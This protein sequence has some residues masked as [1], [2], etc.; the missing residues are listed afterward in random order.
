MIR[1]LIW[2]VALLPLI[3]TIFG[4]LTEVSPDPVK[5]IYTW[6]G[7]TS[8]VILMISLG[9]SSFKRH[10]HVNFLKYRRL[11]GLFAF[12]YAL[13]HFVNFAIIDA[14]L[15]MVFIIKE[16]ADKP[17]VFVGSAL[18][19][20]LLFMAST[21]TKKLFRQYGK[22]HQIIYLGLIL[23]VLHFSWAQKVLEWPQFLAMAIAALLLGERVLLKVRRG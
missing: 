11:V 20:I 8:L 12:F 7:I 22:Y 2:V 15:D 21:S 10:L 14:E 18:F 6:T 13:V 19:L 17:F 3:Y 9:I 23:G 4:V 16:S 5:F 1:V